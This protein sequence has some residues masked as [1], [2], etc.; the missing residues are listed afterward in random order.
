MQSVDHEALK[1]LN[2]AVQHGRRRSVLG[3]S[4]FSAPATHMNEV[5]H[6]S[7][8]VSEEMMGDID[9]ETLLYRRMTKA[10]R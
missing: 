7:G 3:H 8:E 9:E 5:S 6:A 4:E 10:I 2:E 1:M